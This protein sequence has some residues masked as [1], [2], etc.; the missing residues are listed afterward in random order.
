MQFRKMS[1]DSDC[2]ETQQNVPLH[3]EMGRLQLSFSL[4]QLILKQLALIKIMKK[5]RKTHLKQFIFR[6]FNSRAS[7]FT[8]KRTS[9]QMILKNTYLQGQL[10]VTVS[11]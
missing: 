3:R 9:L 2:K 1:L 6:C 11:R 10:L 7:N 8:E 4:Q 5:P